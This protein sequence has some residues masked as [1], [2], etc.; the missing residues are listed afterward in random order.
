MSDQ[1]IQWLRGLAE[2]GGKGVVNNIDARCLGR[3][4]D[5]IE[6]RTAERDMWNQDARRLS[7]GLLK[8]RAAPDHVPASVLRE[9]AYDIALNCLPPDVAEFQIER[10]A[11]LK[12]R[13]QTTL[14]IPKGDQLE[15]PATRDLGG[16]PGK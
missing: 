1:I 11:A 8:I 2:N 10:R 16:D 9:I 12:A 14:P 5:L 4:A 15:S 3:V 7:G 13:Q 6:Y